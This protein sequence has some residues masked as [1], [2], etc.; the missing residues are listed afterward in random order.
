MDDVVAHAPYGF[1]GDF[2]MT[3]VFELSIGASNYLDMLQIIL[4]GGDDMP[5]SVVNA[6]LG[7]YDN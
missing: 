4:S 7:L 1:E 5:S 3:L 2:I 6:G